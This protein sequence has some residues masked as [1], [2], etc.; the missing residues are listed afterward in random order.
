MKPFKRKKTKSP[1]P[2]VSHTK[3]YYRFSKDFPSVTDS[4]GYRDN[5]LIINSPSK[6]AAV[7][8]RLALLFACVFIIAF[9]CTAMCLSIS[10][11][12]IKQ[13]TEQTTD[14]N[15]KTNSLPGFTAA[16][17][18]GDVL[19]YSSVE[20]ILNSFR[21]KSINAVV[22]EF[23]DAQGY[24]YFKPS[25]K[26]SAEAISK[27]SDHASKIISDFKNAGIEVFA[28]VSCFA[29]D[30]YARNHQDHTAYTLSAPESGSY[31]EVRS[32][33]YAG[34]DGENAWLSPYSNEVLYYLNTI[35]SD[36]DVLGV[37]GIIL[38]NAVI[39]LSAESENVRFEFSE[40]YESSAREKM[41]QWVSYTANITNAKT[42]IEIS[43]AQ[44]LAFA[45]KS[46]ADI[47][48]SS[49]CDYIIL[50]AGISDAKEGT[51][52]GTKQY[53]APDKTPKEYT[54]A[55]LTLGADF[56]SK[57]EIEAQIIPVIED[58]DFTD[59]LISTIAALNNEKIRSCI[60]E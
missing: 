5:D 37:N 13:A 59:A 25:I 45:D 50:D 33:W 57:T 27:A 35:I 10:N 29:D 22:I 51:V 36:I 12:P 42:G 38:K 3:G 49:G 40:E 30:I 43:Q 55:L 24:F 17:L 19:S 14:N 32:I 18:S 54:S 44:L 60:I 16:E 53:L 8:R 28:S 21:T 34:E 26:T 47:C 20:S 4:E 41:A 58:G 1:F 23:K 15:I 56:L 52:I 9:S 7:R 31:D 2:Q 39:P 46:E 48:L 11:L 6:K